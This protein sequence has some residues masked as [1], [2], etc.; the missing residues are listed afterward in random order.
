VLGVIAGKV[1][2][3]LGS[4]RLA[5]DGWALASPIAAIVVS[6]FATSLEEA[7]ITAVNLGGD[8]D[9]VG[10]M[11]G[12]IVGAATGPAGVPERLRRFPG[13]EELISWAAA[14]AE[15]R[16]PGGLP[17]LIALEHRLCELGD[18]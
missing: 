13:Y 5:T 4:T 3:V 8:T 2:E 14:A 16:D 7:L 18:G 15:R 11:V 12:G 10:A 1:S 9:T 6:V 17:D